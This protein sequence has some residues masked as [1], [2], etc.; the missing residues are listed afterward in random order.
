MQFLPPPLETGKSNTFNQK[1]TRKRQNPNFNWSGSKG[2]IL[3][4]RMWKLEV[5]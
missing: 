3:E 5:S 1:E 4:S 2:K